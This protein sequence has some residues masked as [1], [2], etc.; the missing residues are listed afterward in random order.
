MD[1]LP[2][3]SFRQCVDRYQGNYRMRSFKAGMIALRKKIAAKPM[4]DQPLLPL[5]MRKAAM[6]LLACGFFLKVSF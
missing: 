3:H 6:D 1:F 5:R 2:R 4:K